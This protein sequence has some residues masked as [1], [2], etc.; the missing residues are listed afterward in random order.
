MP[1]EP[2][3]PRHRRSIRLPGYDYAGAGWYFVTICTHGR[4]CLF[5]EIVNGV[6]V[7]N[8]LGEIVHDEWNQTSMIRPTIE[9]GEFV[10]MPNHFHGIIVIHESVGA[11]GNT[12]VGAYINTPL[13]PDNPTAFRSPSKTIGAVVRGFKSAATKHINIWRNT[14]GAPVWQR[15]YYEHIIR[16]EK[17]Y[18]NITQ[19]ISDNPAN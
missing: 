3:A 15:N 6:M 13:R 14:P 5:G 4:E 17:S 2:A 11:Y 18:L 1:S 9:L 16:N 19:Y 10:V 7:L 8:D 12:P